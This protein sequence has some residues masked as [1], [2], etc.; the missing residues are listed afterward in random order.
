MITLIAG[1]KGTGKTKRIIEMANQDAKSSSGNVIFVDDDKR[2]MYDLKHTLRF[3]SM[4]EYPLKTVDEFFG[5][6]CGLISYDYDID[7][8]YIDGLFK[9]MEA[10]H[11]SIPDFI[12]KLEKIG[13][14]YEIN[15]VATISC[16][17]EELN[18]ELHQYLAEELEE[19]LV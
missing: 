1:P 10:T 4:D 9:V 12:K 3:I 19:V 6:L 16:T 8:I 2:H 15:F 5:F 13:R 17:K 14:E 7:R 18:E 11:E